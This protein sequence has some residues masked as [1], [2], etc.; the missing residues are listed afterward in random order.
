VL[1]D[2]MMPGMGDFEVVPRIC[3]TLAVADIP[4]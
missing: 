2:V 1:L 4:C 3:A